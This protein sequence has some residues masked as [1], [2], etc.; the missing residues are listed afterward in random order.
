MRR[1]L[2]IGVSGV[3]KSTFAAALAERLGLPYVELDALHWGPNWTPN[4]DFG[5]RVARAASA[6]EWIIDGNYSKIRDRLWPQADTIIWLDYPLHTIV[7]RLIVRTIGRCWS[8]QCLWAG[9]RERFGLHWF[10][11]DSVILWAIRTFPRYRRD[12]PPLLLR[13]ARRGTYI[14]R[15]RSPRQAQ[16]WLHD[17]QQVAATIES[18]G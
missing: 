12:Y 17:L 9:N 5:D 3:G 6:P 10:A 13:A 16:Q 14:V 1:V 8:G 4:D 7:R 15:F 2:V 11:W 18:V